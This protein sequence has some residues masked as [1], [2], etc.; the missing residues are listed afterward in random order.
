MTPK[1][2]LGLMINPY[3]WNNNLSSS[4]SYNI[5]ATYNNKNTKDPNFSFDRRFH[6]NQESFLKK[7]NRSGD[8]VVANKIKIG[9]LKKTDVCNRK[10]QVQGNTK[11]TPTQADCNNNRIHATYSFC[12]PI[13]RMKTVE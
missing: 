10:E 13:L 3:S 4:W 5:Q 7:Q 1:L 11:T 6:K 12:L 9:A 8:W 2:I